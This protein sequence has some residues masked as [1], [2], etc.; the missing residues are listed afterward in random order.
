M[1]NS[2]VKEK[3]KEGTEG[4]KNRVGLGIVF[5]RLKSL[6]NKRGGPFGRGVTS[7]GKEEENE[8]VFLGINR[9]ENWRRL[10]NGG[11]VERPRS[12][13]VC[14]EKKKLYV[15][16]GGG[17]K[18]DSS[19]YQSGLK[20]GQTRCRRARASAQKIFQRLT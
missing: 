20:K 4:T 14:G 9:K 10:N 7:S 19:R 3:K 13:K 1:R 11:N 2:C 15:G 6:E 17:K 16:G 8:K 18:K 12:Y 5:M